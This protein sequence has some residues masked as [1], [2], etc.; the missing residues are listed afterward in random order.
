M[1]TSAR[2]PGRRGNRPARTFDAR[3]GQVLGSAPSD[4]VDFQLDP[5]ADPTL[6]F[7][8]TGNQSAAGLANPLPGQSTLPALPPTPTAGATAT[9]QTTGPLGLPWWAWGVLGILG[10]YFIARQYG[11]KIG[12]ALQPAG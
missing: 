8:T 5:L 6:A 7:D 2:P 10:G 9:G 3:T 4:Y 1:A 11:H 12:R